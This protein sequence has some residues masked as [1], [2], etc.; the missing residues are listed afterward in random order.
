LRQTRES[1]APVITLGAVAPLH[2]KETAAR[3]RDAHRRGGTR[4]RGPSPPERPPPS[5]ATFPPP[6]KPHA[7]G[8]VHGPPP[9]TPPERPQSAS[10]NAP[11][12]PQADAASR[13]PIVDPAISAGIWSSGR[14][15]RPGRA[16]GLD[17][18]GSHRPRDPRPG[19]DGGVELKPCPDPDRM[20]QTVKPGG[21]LRTTLGVCQ[22]L[23]LLSELPRHAKFH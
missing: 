21:E 16:D 6:S 2:A 19:D 15:D 8:G 5:A 12:T 17:P 3:D 20:P 1:E 4:D 18:A 23:S 10:G 14:D 11:G 22:T 9:G 13:R 7:F